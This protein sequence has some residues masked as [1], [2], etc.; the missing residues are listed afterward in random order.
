MGPGELQDPSPNLNF[1]TAAC[2][3]GAS[4]ASASVVDDTKGSVHSK[5]DGEVVVDAGVKLLVSAAF[6]SGWLAPAYRALTELAPWSESADDVEGSP[7]PVMHVGCI[8]KM[9]M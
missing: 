6:T 5:V 4:A 8:M 9:L 1:S 2:P 3:I 7:C